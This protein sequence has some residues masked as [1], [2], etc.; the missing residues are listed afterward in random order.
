PFS[1]KAVLFA[2]RVRDLLSH[3]QCIKKGA[4]IP[5]HFDSLILVYFSNITAKEILIMTNFNQTRWQS[6]LAETSQSTDT[7]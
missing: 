1:A 3:P 2:Q 5:S 4:K 6:L 7:N